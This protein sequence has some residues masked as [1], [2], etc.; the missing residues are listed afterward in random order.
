[1]IKFDLILIITKNIEG[2]N[3]MKKFFLTIE[4]ALIISINISNAQKM[5]CVDTKYI[6]ENIGEYR[7]AQAKLDALSIQWQKEIE[8][9]LAE[10]DKL[11]KNFQAEA[12]LLPEEVKNKRQEEIINKE[13]EVKELQKK[14][15]GAE[16]DLFKK[17]QE[18]IKPIQDKVYNAIE[19]YASE[20]NYTMIFDKAGGGA[21][22]LYVNPK[23]EISDEILKKL[24]YKPGAVK[25]EQGGEEE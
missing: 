14:R 23:N 17:R 22:V 1:L 19:E 7:D 15:F 8:T 2:E 16:G 10:I 21:T 11:Y 25:S 6:L 12:V 4:L 18:L 13:K 20:K 9:K 24:G 3:I 5:A